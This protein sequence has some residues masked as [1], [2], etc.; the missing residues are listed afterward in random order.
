MLQG[1]QLSA[2]K[3]KPGRPQNQNQHECDYQFPTHGRQPLT[4]N[5]QH[6]VFIDTAI[7]TGWLSWASH[8]GKYPKKQ[9]TARRAANYPI[10]GKN[11]FA[12]FCWQE[13]GK[14][15]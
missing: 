2:V 1:L 10:G 14:Q 5:P 7:I 4:P 9:P 3:G 13:C 12:T 15:V 8:I 11:E 6:F